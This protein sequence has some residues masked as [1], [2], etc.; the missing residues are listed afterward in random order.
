LE[1]STSYEAPRY[2]VFSNLQET[3]KEITLRLSFGRFLVQIWARITT[4]LIK[5][6]LVFLRISRIMVG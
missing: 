2:A 1:K 4:I 6:A 5:I 3:K